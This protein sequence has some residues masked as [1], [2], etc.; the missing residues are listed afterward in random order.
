MISLISSIHTILFLL[1]E[2]HGASRLHFSYQRKSE[3]THHHFIAPSL[4]TSSHRCL[5][6][7]LIVAVISW[8]I[9][10]FYSSQAIKLKFFTLD[11]K[12]ISSHVVVVAMLNAD[13]SIMQYVVWGSGS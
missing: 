11:E 3:N 1:V 6:R 2:A 5:N 7:V 12:S 4:L 8:V 13:A 9:R 10:I